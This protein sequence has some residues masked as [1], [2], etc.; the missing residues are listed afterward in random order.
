MAQTPATAREKR[1][2][3]WL[4]YAGWFLVNALAI[5]LIQA[6][7]G[8]SSGTTV[9]PTIN[10]GGKGASP[11]GPAPLGLALSG[12]LILLNIAT[13]IVLAFYRRWAALGI[14]VAFAT[15]FALTVIEGV[16]FTVSDFVG[17]ISNT[18]VSVTFLVVG[19]ILFAIGAFFVLRRIHRSIR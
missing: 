16:F 18:R 1:K 4:A 2:D 3:F 12:L 6:I 5:F 14:L 8:S 15:A 17:G 7:F 11:S 13:P 9:S 19:F 10:T